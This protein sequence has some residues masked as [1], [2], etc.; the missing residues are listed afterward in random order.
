MSSG[1]MTF[2]QYIEGHLQYFSLNLKTG[3]FGHHQGFWCFHL[4]TWLVSFVLGALF[5]FCFYRGAKKSTAGVPGGFQNLLEL[6]IEFVGKQ[7]KDTCPS[8]EGYFLS[9]F[10]LTIFVWVFL[11]NTMDIIPLDFV[12]Y[13]L[14]LLGLP[15]LRLVPTADLN[16]TAALGLTVFILIF[17][18]MFKSKGL[19]GVLSEFLLHPFHHPLMMP[20]NLILKI[21]EEVAK[22]VSMSLRLFGN[23]YAGELIFIL[24]SGLLPWWTQWTLGLVWTVFHVLVIVLQAF[25]FMML[26][27]VY[28]SLARQKH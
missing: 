27:I 1:A 11:M 24:I 26:T 3:E 17:I 15:H 19:K 20:V 23:I 5:I 28:V 16:M 21:V 4:D 14:G 25:I 10:A 22:P 13:L 8:D 12:P 9:S 2:P 7:V 18:Y 6:L